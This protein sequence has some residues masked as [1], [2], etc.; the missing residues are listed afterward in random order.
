MR[1]AA[2]LLF[3]VGIFVL[4]LTHTI[5]PGI[6]VLI[7][8]STCFGAAARGRGDQALLS[9]IWWGGLALLFASG[10]FW[11]GILVLIFLSMVF[12]G[13]G[14]GFGGWW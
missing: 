1:G 13:R 11:P 8:I 14:R 2:P 4:L 3:V 7:G 9:L 5:W 12:G 6:L 10:T